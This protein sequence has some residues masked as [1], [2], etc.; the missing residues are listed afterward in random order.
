MCRF[1]TTGVCYL[2]WFVCCYDV[3]LLVWCG[4]CFGFTCCVTVGLIL[5]ACLWFV[6]VSVLGVGI[7]VFALLVWLCTCCVLCL[8]FALASG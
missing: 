1:G 7:C 6:L 4:V 2:N 3:L 8:L 5:L